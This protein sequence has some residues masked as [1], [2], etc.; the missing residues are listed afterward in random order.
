MTFVASINVIKYLDA[1]PVF[2]D[3]DNNHNLDVK[4]LLVLENNTYF[5]NS[6]TF[7][8]KSKKNF[9]FNSCICGETL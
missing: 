1:N 9:S 8:K 2:M 5:K 4:K 7:N 3:V 6:S